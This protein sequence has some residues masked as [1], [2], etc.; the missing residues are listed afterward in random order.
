MLKCSVDQALFNLKVQGQNEELPKKKI[1][2][3]GKKDDGDKSYH[4]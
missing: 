4:N 1:K 2:T 3:K